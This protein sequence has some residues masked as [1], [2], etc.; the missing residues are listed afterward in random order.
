M[1]NAFDD[2][3]EDDDASSMNSSHF[4]DASRD[5]DHSGLENSSNPPA[6]ND[7]GPTISQYRNDFGIYVSDGSSNYKSTPYPQTED[8]KG[9]TVSDMQR[10]FDVYGQLETPINN[11]KENNSFHSSTGSPYELPRP[12]KAINSAFPH[13]LRAQINDGLTLLENYPFNY[14]TPSNHYDGHNTNYPNNGYIGAYENNIQNNS[15]EHGGGDN[16]D[17]SEHFNHCYKT[18]PNGQ[19]IND[20]N[21]YKAS[22][23]N[24]KE[25]LEVL[26]SVRMRE[27]KQLTEQLQQLQLDREEEKNQHSRKLALIQAENERI[28]LSRNQAQNALVDAKAVIIELQTQAASFKEKIAIMEKTNKNMAEE[29]SVA[30]NSVVE[31]QQKIGVLE[32]VQSLQANDKTHEK[33]LKQAQDKHAS[34]MSNMQTHIDILTAKLNEKVK[35]FIFILLTLN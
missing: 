3:E 17:S 31:L 14:N 33:F 5:V 6:K 24:S 1:T 32:R 4:H 7:K 2:L 21:A 9:P 10:E 18:S 20:I 8:N 28:N 30:R 34:D 23:Y 19:P 25:Q 29:L 11:N 22:E 35:F 26:Y 27:I 13:D 12:P 15:C 16:D